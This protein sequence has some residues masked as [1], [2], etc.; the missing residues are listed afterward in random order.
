MNAPP[1]SGAYQAASASEVIL[2]QDANRY[3]TAIFFDDAVVISARAVAR[4]QIAARSTGS[5][6]GSAWCFR[7]S[8]YGRT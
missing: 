3:F 4:S 5:A 8:I 2:S 6:R 1:T 7:A